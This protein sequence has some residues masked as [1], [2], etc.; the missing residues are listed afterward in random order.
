MMI[1]SVVVRE[2]R[3]IMR[4]TLRRYDVPPDTHV[5][6]EEPPEMV[7]D[8]SFDGIELRMT[9]IT[10][11]GRDADWGYA[12][13]HVPGDVL[14]APHRRLYSVLRKGVEEMVEK[15]FGVHEGSGLP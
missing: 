9:H 7:R 5:T 8:E 2:A 6:L 13:M 3:R 4:E 1:D 12:V 15:L 10:G 14:R 11:Y